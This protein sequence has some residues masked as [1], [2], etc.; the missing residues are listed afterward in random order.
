MSRILVELLYRFWLYFGK[1][2]AWKMRRAKDREP[3]YR[4]YWVHRRQ[5][6]EGYM[7]T[8]T[9]YRPTPKAI[10]LLDLLV[11]YSPLGQLIVWR[12]KRSD[13]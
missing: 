12:T 6:A 8:E 9:R 11:W 13:W 3:E 7:G 4:E 5:A 2:M 1:F 10:R